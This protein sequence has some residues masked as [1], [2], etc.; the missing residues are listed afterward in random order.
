MKH[1]LLIGALICA[2]Y[3][4]SQT[5]I[6]LQPDPITGVDAYIESGSNASINYSSYDNYAA[7]AWTR[8]SNPFVSRGLLKFDLTSIPSNAIITNAKLSLH[9]NTTSDQTQLH[10]SLSG[11]NGCYLERIT[12]LWGE[13][14]VNWNNQPATTTLNRVSLAQSTSSTQDYIDI[15]VDNIVQDM[16]LNPATS[17]GFMLKLGTESYYRSMQFGSSDH[18]ILSKRPKLEI[19]YILPPPCAHTIVLRPDSTLGKDTYIENGGNSSSNF[20]SYFN[21][22]AIAWTRSSNPFISRSFI[23]FNLSSIPPNA[24]I[25]SAQLNLYCNTISDQTQLHSSLSGS[26]E[27]V[28][29]KV[30][31]PWGEKTMTWNNQPS[32]TSINRI[33]LPQ[34]TSSTQDYLNINLRSMIQDMVQLPSTNYGMVLKLLN[35]SVYRS[36]QFASSDHPDST[37]RPRLEICYSLPAVAYP[38]VLANLNNGEKI[39]RNSMKRIAW[40][41]INATANVSIQYT[42]NNGISWSTITAMTKD[43]GFFDWNVPDSVSIQCRV[44]VASFE[45]PTIA[46]TSNVM[47]TI[48]DPPGYTVLSPNGGEV[49]FNDSIVQIRWTGSQRNNAKIE[50]TLN[51]TSWYPV[52]ANINVTDTA[53]LWVPANIASTKV[54]IRV[55]DN[56]FPQYGDTVNAVFTI[57][58][59]PKFA[60][61]YPNTANEL[62]FSG[63]SKTITWS[64]TDSRLGRL[65]CSVNNGPWTILADSIS[66]LV[67]SYVYTPIGL[68]K[69]V[70]QFRLLDLDVTYKYYTSAVVK[71]YE[72]PALNFVSPNGGE[73]LFAGNTKTIT[74]TS[75]YS[76]SVNLYYSTDGSSWSLIA[77]NIIATTGSYSWI[78]P[79][80]PSNTYRLL[81]TDVRFTSVFDTTSAVFSIRNLPQ[82]TFVNPGPN[83]NWLIGDEK[84]ISWTASNSRYARIDYSI[85][86]NTWVKL[87]DSIPSS[88]T[89]V[90]WTPAGLH[91]STVKFRISDIDLSATFT[92]SPSVKI[93]AKPVLSVLSPNAGERIIKGSV[94]PVTWSALYSDSVDIYY[95][96]NGTSWNPVAI[97]T[98]AGSGIFNWTV[99]IINSSTV[100]LRIADSRFGNYSD[101]TDMLFKIISMP[102]I[103][104][105]SP[106]GGEMWLNTGTYPITWI[107]S[108]VMKMTILYTVDD[109]NWV[110]VATSVPASN[111]SYNWT[112]PVI[113]S[114]KVRVKLV[115]EDFSNI[116][117]SSNARFAILT[118]PSV[119]LL[120]PNGG[121]H[122]YTDST[123]NITWTS[124]NVPAVHLFY[125]LND[126]ILTMIA[127]NIPSINTTN[128][129]SWT[130]PSALVS[131][132]VKVLIR[133]IVD[134]LVYDKSDAVFQ[135]SV[136]IPSGLNDVLFTEDDVNLYPNPSNGTFTLTTPI[137][138]GV[139]RVSIL[140]ISGKL[141]F[142]RAGI[143]TASVS[144]QLSDQLEQGIYMVKVETESGA[145]VVK[146]LVLTK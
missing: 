3:T 11:S 93:Y 118:P 89:T 129:Y 109:T 122:W 60:F 34:S 135:T 97:N 63:T 58:P 80:S 53:F 62:W 69:A 19:T 21:F 143:T 138:I 32:S 48:S 85:D 37:K 134:S 142:E 45:T 132:S 30:T 90:K 9:C 23:E 117:D 54:K 46:D 123:Y 56:L 10:S 127:Q 108:D 64:N 137:N 66:P 55:V 99:P 104:L 22:A 51:D 96:T 41:S 139:Y 119:S 124:I 145:K 68:H 146:R 33:T 94:Y 7:I 61:S 82:F 130:I 84:V 75:S 12:G 128:S 38:I 110:T 141:L 73:W 87:A 78:M 65:E 49:Y 126:T 115:D 120:S 24:V 100:R 8:S 43:T 133:N 121:E 116:I 102:V 52:T 31:S 144:C 103:S 47:F 27:C 67:S 28:I 125:T 70:V 39:L 2:Q 71:V 5:T 1:I 50:Y 74:W 17:F 76:D 59:T 131:S 136:F 107:T 14:T 113:N 29:E 4:F 79:T 106:N 92:M 18:A 77:S 72:K 16:I 26:N 105:V 81:M 112:L 6:I 57:K 98:D 40:T 140:D 35:E 83:Q 42:L 88:I 91:K 36:L 95:S 111:G 101:T 15:N 86:S 13:S 25:S 20:G 44:R 114:A